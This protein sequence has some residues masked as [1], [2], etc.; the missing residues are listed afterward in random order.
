MAKRTRKAE[1]YEILANRKDRVKDGGA[2]LRPDDIAETAPSVRARTGREVIFSLD[3]AFVIFGAVLLLTGSAY[4]IGHK[5]GED[6][7]QLKFD[8]LGDSAAALD[9]GQ[10]PIGVVETERAALRPRLTQADPEKYTI[11]LRVSDGYA[12]ADKERLEL[13]R[14]QL[15][16]LP[17]VRQGRHN[18]FVFEKK[19]EGVYGLALG[20]FSASDDP[21][22][23]LLRERLKSHPGRHNDMPYKHLSVERIGT[24]LD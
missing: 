24:L 16:A 13:E 9:A 1:L 19:R 7:A 6:A 23:V 11:L 15:Y 8:R 10:K 17:P 2:V 18:V 14:E 22:I 12:D 5:K 3:V 20:A 21:K 4:V